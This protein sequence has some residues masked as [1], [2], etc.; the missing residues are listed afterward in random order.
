V[1]A[2]R[3]KHRGRETAQEIEQRLSREA[4]QIPAS[5]RTIRIANNTDLPTA[6]QAFVQAIQTTIASPSSQSPSPPLPPTNS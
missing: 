4:A 6:I 1:L 2:E 3:L 5:L